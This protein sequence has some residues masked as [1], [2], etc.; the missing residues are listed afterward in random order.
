MDQRQTLSKSVAV[1]SGRQG[2]DELAGKQETKEKYP[3]FYN[4][5]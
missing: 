4:G 5:E 3:K 2:I 1:D